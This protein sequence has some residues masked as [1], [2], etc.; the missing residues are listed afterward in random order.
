MEVTDESI[1]MGVPFAR[2]ERYQPPY[3]RPLATYK[4][5]LEEQVRR[6]TPRSDAVGLPRHPRGRSEHTGTTPRPTLRGGI[7]RHA[8]RLRPCSAEP[9]AVFELGAVKPAP[10]GS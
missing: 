6:R 10:L 5:G 4:K 7:P 1:R 9:V 2:C 8:R 3:A